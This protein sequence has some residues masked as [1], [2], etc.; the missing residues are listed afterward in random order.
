MQNLEN[1]VQETF[2]MGLNGGSRKNG[3]F[4]RENWPY[5]P[6]SATVKVAISH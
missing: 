6:N 1:A 2:L 3:S 4:S 5:R